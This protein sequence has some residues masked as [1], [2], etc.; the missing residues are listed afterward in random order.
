MLE[1]DFN[2]LD[3]EVIDYDISQAVNPPQKPA[4]DQDNFYPADGTNDLFFSEAR[5]KGKARRASKKAAKQT[6]RQGT[7]LDKNERAARRTRRGELITSINNR[8]DARVSRKQGEADTQREMVR[9]LGD[10]AIQ[11]RSMTVLPESAT[12]TTGMSTTAK[13]G[14]ALGILAVVGIGYMMFKGKKSGK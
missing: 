5:G 7:I 10:T 11:D 2:N 4:F 1:Q 12:P 3:G 9:G 14:I 6:K 8:Q 13:V